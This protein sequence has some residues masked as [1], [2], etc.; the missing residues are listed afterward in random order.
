LTGRNRLDR[1][2]AF[3]DISAEGNSIL[4]KL[5]IRNALKSLLLADLKRV[6]PQRHRRTAVDGL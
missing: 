5:F 2:A 3:G 6:S 1:Q 4:R